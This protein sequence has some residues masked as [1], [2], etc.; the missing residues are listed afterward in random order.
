LQ[1]EMTQIYRDDQNRS[2]SN[3]S[4][5]E[6]MQTFSPVCCKALAYAGAQKC[7]AKEKIAHRIC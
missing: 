7:C 5:D 2:I 3:Y 1:L 6:M 4:I